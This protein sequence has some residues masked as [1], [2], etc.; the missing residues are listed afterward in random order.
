MH[1]EVIQDVYDIFQSTTLVDSLLKMTFPNLYDHKALS[2]ADQLINN[3]K[4]I[5]APISYKRE[6]PLAWSTFWTPQLVK[7]FKWKYAN[8]VSMQEVYEEENQKQ[9]GIRR[10]IRDARQ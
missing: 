6:S 4:T 5:Q 9:D 3:S 8:S 1:Y 2:K 10:A 7:Q